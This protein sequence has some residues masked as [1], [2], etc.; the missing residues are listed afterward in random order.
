MVWETP[1]G[2]LCRWDTWSCSSMGLLSKCLWWF[3]Q[4][5]TVPSSISIL[6]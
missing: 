6:K 1:Q 2:I 4:T 5:A 3:P